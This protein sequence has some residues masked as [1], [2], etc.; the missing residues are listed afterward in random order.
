[1]PLQREN[2]TI[3]TYPFKSSGKGKK[4]PVKIPHICLCPLVLSPDP[5][6]RLSLTKPVGRAD[7]R[8]S[9]TL[10]QEKLAGFHNSLQRI[11][12]LQ[13]VLPTG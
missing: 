4:K 11:T 7:S 1:V 10:I 6:V 9:Q 2:K 13:P 3:A 12:A 5:R 8:Y